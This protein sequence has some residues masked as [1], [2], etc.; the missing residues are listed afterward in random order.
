MKPET[1]DDLIAAEAI[2]KVNAGGWIIIEAG[3][4]L[5]DGIYAD[6]ETA[7]EVLKYMH[8]RAPSHDHL[9]VCVKSGLRG[10]NSGYWIPDKS[11]WARQSPSSPTKEA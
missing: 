5:M 9:L 1:L 2:L 10:N 8:G 6:R 11:F 3:T 4:G 7:W